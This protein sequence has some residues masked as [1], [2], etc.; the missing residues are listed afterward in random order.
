MKKHFPKI[1]LALLIMLLPTTM[2]AQKIVS[3]NV[4]DFDATLSTD[5]I[6]DFQTVLD[7]LQPDILIVQDIVDADAVT[8]FLNKVLNHEK[9][10]YKKAK[11][12]NQDGTQSTLFYNKKTIKV[13]KVV[14]EI[15][16]LS[17]PVWGYKVK[18]K[19]GEGKGKTLYL[20]SVHLAE[21]T[22]ATAKNSRDA[23][24]QIIRDHLDN[25]HKSGDYF[26]VCGTFNFAGAADNAFKILTG[27]TAMDNGRLIDPLDIPG[28]WHKKKKFA[29]THTVSTR[30]AKSDVGASGGLISRFDMFFISE[31][32]AEDKKFTYKDGSNI[33]YGNDGKHFKKA[34][35]VP[36][37][38]AVDQDIAEATYRASD[39]LA[40]V[41]ELGAPGSG[42]PMAPSELTAAALSSASV[43]LDWKD[44]SDNEDGFY[45]YRA[46]E[47]FSCHGDT[48]CNGCHGGFPGIPNSPIHE[49]SGHYY[50]WSQIQTMNTNVKTYTDDGLAGEKTYKYKVNAFNPAGKSGYS[51]IASTKTP[52][53]ATSS[54]NKDK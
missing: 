40:L 29:D 47:C 3:W 46:T 5:R 16:T 13:F 36:D 21:G 4:L 52:A 12:K 15:T 28:K 30:K 22:T 27:S 38:K 35:T 24:A 44:N 11:F 39:H 48:H 42:P 37:N 1:I 7:E 10:L 50:S 26:L 54:K 20:Y 14:D 17:R 25:K 33:A 53:A 45:V 31:G 34:V 2:L 41:I 18:I 6:E 19:K 32:I 49:M 43:K 23:D 51:N 8:L 9:K